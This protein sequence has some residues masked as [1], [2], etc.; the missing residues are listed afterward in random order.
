MTDEMS[1]QD[2]KAIA[3]GMIILT[4]LFFACFPSLG[5]FLI[6]TAVTLIIAPMLGAGIFASWM[7][8]LGA[9]LVTFF[10]IFMTSIKL[11]R[12]RLESNAA[13]NREAAALKKVEEEVEAEIQDARKGVFNAR[14]QGVRR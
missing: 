4:A 2:K 14:R 3:E 13:K 1:P 11:I 8:A 6:V 12:R 10:P 5:G 9:G 7:L